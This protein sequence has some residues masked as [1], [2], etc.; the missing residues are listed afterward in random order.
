MT[1][2]KGKEKTTQYVLSVFYYETLAPYV[3]PII[4]QVIQCINQLYY[5]CTDSVSCAE[6]R[7]MQLYHGHPGPQ[8][9]HSTRIIP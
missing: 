2:T 9:R 5:K 8:V 6:M 7:K 3:S 1:V 4:L